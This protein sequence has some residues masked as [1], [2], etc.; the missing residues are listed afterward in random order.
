MIYKFITNIPELAQYAVSCGVSRIF[1]DMEYIGKEE[2][3]GHLNTHKAQ[4]TL[5]DVRAIR[6][7]APET[8]LLVRINPFYDGTASE[9]D[10]AI[11]EGADIIMLPMFKRAVEVQEVIRII[12][13]R[14]KL[15]LLLETPQ[16]M[17][18]LDEILKLKSGIDEIHIGLND[19]HLGL[20]LDFMFEVLTGGLVEFM[21]EKIKKAG[22]RFGFGGIARIGDGT[23]PA[24]LILGEHVRLGSEMVMLS[25]TFHQNLKSVE[26]L[27]ERINLA[28]EIEKL[29]ESLNYFRA[30]TNGELL[31][32]KDN[33]IN[34]VRELVVVVD[35]K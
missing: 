17:V 31:K 19:M 2:R 16:A 32:N 18:R 14:A 21:V 15:C 12:N 27:E 11:R 9:I 26:E 25:R 13:S 1:V 34:A 8:E 3:Q 10:G 22:I 7:A 4:H 30:Q 5:D 33:L 6:R 24:E 23:V 28:R 20:G 35:E 29:N